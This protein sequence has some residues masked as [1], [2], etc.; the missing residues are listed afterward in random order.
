MTT[1]VLILT[2]GYQGYGV[3]MTSVP[4]FESEVACQTAGTT[5]TQSTTKAPGTRPMFVCVEQKK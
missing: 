5:W 1:F 2:I 4:G 3:A